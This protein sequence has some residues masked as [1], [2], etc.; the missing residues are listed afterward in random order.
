MVNQVETAVAGPRSK[1]AGATAKHV[2]C[3][4][5]CGCDFNSKKPGACPARRMK[6]SALRWSRLLERS[7]VEAH[8]YLLALIAREA[9]VPDA[10]RAPLP[11]AM[12]MLPAAVALDIGA[13]QPKAGLSWR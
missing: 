6:Q 11:M 2:K 12:M 10:D 1:P 3:R 4:S 8:A 13:V 7:V 9:M 5:G